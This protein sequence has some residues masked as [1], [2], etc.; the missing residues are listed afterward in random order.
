[1]SIATTALRLTFEALSRSGVASMAQPWTQGMG[2][3]FCMHR[4]QPVQPGVGAFQPN[5]NLSS[6]PEFLD[7]ALMLLRQ[8]GFEF[9]SLDAA[10]A[11]IARQERGTKPFAVFTL[12][13]GYRD[14]LQ[15][16]MPVFLKHACPFTVYVAPG[17][18]DGTTE[19][20]WMALEQIINR[21]VGQEVSIG[22]TRLSLSS[23]DVDKWKAW[24]ILA[25]KVQGMPEHDQREWIRKEAVRFEVD[26]KQM[27]LS[28]IM[29]W[30]EVK[31]MAASPLA[32]IGAHTNNHFAVARLNEDEA[33]EEIVQSGKR[34]EME[35][36][37]PVKHFAFPYGNVGHAEQRDFR[38]CLEAGYTTAVTTRLG[39]VFEEHASHMHALPR[40]MVS[41]KYQEPRWLRV[42][43][44]GLPG[45]LANRGY[46]LNVG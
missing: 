5:A 17:F 19:M 44:Q 11:R 22:D 36:N 28:E 26:L 23:G 18:V 30:E 37:R 21:G 4:V 13:D 45:R 41:G 1:M 35:L 12:D 43:A 33:R 15:H 39:T 24:R 27:C 42:L 31:A 38:L 14:N 3:I 40:V 2:V 34:L 29:S 10:A 8:S 9:L 7:A 46:R 6:T 16:A 20:W 25:P 32:T